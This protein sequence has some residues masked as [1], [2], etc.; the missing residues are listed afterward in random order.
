MLLSVT[1]P[2]PLIAAPFLF[3]TFA[4][5]VRGLPSLLLA[6]FAIVV[7]FGAD[8]RGSLWY[9]ERGWAVLVAGWFASL[10]LARPK[11]RFFTRA[12]VSI[13]GAFLVTGVLFGTR[14]GAWSQVDWRMRQSLLEGAQNALAALQLFQG[15]G[16]GAST[17]LVAAVMRTAEQQG[18][19]FP[20]LLGLSSMAALAVAWWL[21]VRLGW[22]SG[23]GLAPLAEFRFNDHL[24]WL[25]VA[26]LGS[27]VLGMGDAWSR[28]GTNTV[29]FMG[30]LY[31]L[32]GAA[33]V[34]FLTGGLSMVSAVF[35]GL[36]M[37]FLAPVVVGGA[38]ILGL[39][40]TWLDVRAHV[41]RTREPRS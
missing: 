29:V 17:A 24:V 9:L 35:L 36:G 40:D 32:R 2:T 20:A 13:A 21:Y 38:L 27:L 25:F 26:G 18:E 11:S 8:I 14:T 23:R 39:G 12:L 6:G 31:A 37:L 1:S 22:R 7:L 41:D 15:E 30:G 34:T 4:V 10:T 33:V 28:A 3:L 19:L 16:A 5:G